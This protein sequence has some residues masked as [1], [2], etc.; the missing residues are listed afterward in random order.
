MVITRDLIFLL[1]ISSSLSYALIAFVYLIILGW[2]KFVVL[3][4]ALLH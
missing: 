3:I 4:Q 2:P 1:K